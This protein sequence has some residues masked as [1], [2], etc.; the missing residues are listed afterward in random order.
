MGIEKYLV[1]IERNGKMT[2]IGYIAGESYKTAR[3]A[4]FE[5]YLQ[6]RNA[7]PVPNCFLRGFCQRDLP[8][9]L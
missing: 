7:V 3:F 1:N 4:Y 9:D 8:E 5:H 6:D 2:P